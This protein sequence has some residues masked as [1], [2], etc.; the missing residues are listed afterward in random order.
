MIAEIRHGKNKKLE[1]VFWH[2]TVQPEMR[3][4]VESTDYFFKNEDFQ[5]RFELSQDQASNI[6]IIFFNGSEIHDI[7]LFFCT[8]SESH[9]G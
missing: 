9:L 2:P 3:N 6:A 4:A 5:D 1:P 8:Q 7:S